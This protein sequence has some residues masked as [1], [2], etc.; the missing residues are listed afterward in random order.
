MVRKIIGAAAFAAGA[1]LIAN[2][3]PVESKI[4]E[5]LSSPQVS[6]ALSSVNENDRNY[7]KMSTGGAL[8]IIGLGLFASAVRRR[9][10]DRKD[11]S[12]LETLS[13]QVADLSGQ[14]SAGV[15]VTQED[16]ERVKDAMVMLDTRL[17]KMDKNIAEGVGI[18]TERLESAVA[19]LAEF[20]AKAKSLPGELD[21]RAQEISQILDT[22]EGRAQVL[23]KQ[24]DLTRPISEMQEAT[25]Q[26]LSSLK[27]K[28]E[29]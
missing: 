23:I 21:L 7:L 12:N 17:G 11:R 6:A 14:F 28:I 25:E 3:E 10:R 8:G 29:N 19:T 5:I 13:D 1:A 4:D 15:A 22:L 27:T 18:D 2:T 20:E 9:E 26:A 24:N 16:I